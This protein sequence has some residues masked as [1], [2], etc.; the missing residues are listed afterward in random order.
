LAGID[1][2]LAEIDGTVAERVLLC[3]AQY[4]E[5]TSNTLA[6]LLNVGQIDVVNARTWLV[7]LG[8]A[9]APEPLSGHFGLTAQG[10]AAATRLNYKRGSNSAQVLAC[11]TALLRFW[12]EDDRD[13][14]PAP[15]AILG[16]EH[17]WRDGQQFTPKQVEAAA[18]WLHSHDLIKTVGGA[19]R[20][21]L[22]ATLS[23]SGRDCLLRFDGDVARWLDRASVRGGDTY[24][25]TITHSPGAQAMTASPG[26]SQTSTTTL[27]RAEVR[28]R[29]VSIAD[30]IL[31][32]VNGVDLPE[33]QRHEVTT[34]ATE[35]K[36]VAGEPD[37]S[38]GRVKALLGAI[39]LATAT[40]AGTEAG[41]GLI[42]LA[43][44]GLTALTG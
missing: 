17:S 38:P 9:G 23:P 40:S 4:G 42:Q 41:Q 1:E 5:M 35:L 22:G 12:E 29:L 14:G 39:A 27:I 36:Q 26:G 43:G 16:T 44:Q 10:E 19:E 7:D 18:R 37:A 21:I 24:A 8:L 25:T 2:H 6:Q 28:E 3:L 30:R 13:I 32:D 31:R 33:P 11:A 20:A 15:M 34:A